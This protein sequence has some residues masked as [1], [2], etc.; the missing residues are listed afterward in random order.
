MSDPMKSVEHTQRQ[1]EL[2]A[3]RQQR[4]TEDPEFFLEV[5]LSEATLRHHVGNRE[6]IHEQLT[7]LAS[8]G[9]L[10]NVSIRVIP[11]GAG[12]HS[13]LVS[14]SFT[15]FEF[16]SLHTSRS[17]EPPVVFVEGFTGALFLEDEGMIERHRA[18]VTG[19]RAV[20]LSEEDT[21]RLVLEIAEEYGV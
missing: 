4:I 21:R 20:A 6:V 19:I 10:Q 11:F 1:L 8:L 14:Q 16:R 15:L 17:P 9:R 2:T 18:A 13:G 12:P 3:R 5:L 7:H